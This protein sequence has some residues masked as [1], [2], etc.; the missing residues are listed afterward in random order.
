MIEQYSVRVRTQEVRQQ[1]NH[2]CSVAWTVSRLSLANGKSSTS[3]I[4][5]ALYLSN[6][7]VP[8]RE[9]WN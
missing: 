2:D 5:D 9:G 3:R 4:F 1:E 8:T 6:R 7:K